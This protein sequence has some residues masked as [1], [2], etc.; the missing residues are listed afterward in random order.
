MRGQSTEAEK[1]LWLVF[2]S[3]QFMGLKFR[4]QCSIGGYF[5]DFACVEL[6]II[7]EAD[8]G[9]HSECAADADRTSRLQAA[10]YEVIRYWNNDIFENMEGVLE[11]LRDRVSAITS[12]KSPHPTLSQGE[13]GL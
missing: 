9:Q 5:A 12:G 11:D 4:R 7:V 13:R 2:R 8:G 3:R 6:K 10:G 1:R